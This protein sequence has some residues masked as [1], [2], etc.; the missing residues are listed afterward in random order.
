[1]HKNN[2]TLSMIVQ[3]L[4]SPKIITLSFLGF[5]SIMFLVNFLF[6]QN[7][8]YLTQTFNYSPQYTY[9]LLTDI[10]AAGRTR[11]LLV[12]L[13]DI[14]MV[15]LYTA[16][17][18]GSNYTVFTR[19]TQNCTIISIITFSPILLSV[20]QLSE[21]LVLAFIIIRFPTMML[22]LVQAVNVITM[23]KIILTILCFLMPL[24][25]LCILTLKKIVKRRGRV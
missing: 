6:K 14:A 12:F 9:Q 19:L 11:H 23:V 20:V 25:G 7:F 1:M 8:S 10:G 13:P 18:T 22:T 17:L 2:K 4:A 24:L 16:L 3:K 5:I 15:L 21:I